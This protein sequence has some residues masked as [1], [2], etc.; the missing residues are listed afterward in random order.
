MLFNSFTFLFG[1]L[2]AAV[3]VYWCLLAFRRTAAIAFLALASLVFYSWWDVRYLP[4]FCGSILF[5]Y[6]MGHL[7]ARARVGQPGKA[8]GLLAF[9]IAADLAVLGYFKYIGLFADAFA[10]LTGISAAIPAVVL[11]L[12]I[13]FFTFTQITYIVDSLKGKVQERGFWNYVL[14]VS[15]FPHQVAGPILHHAEMMSQFRTVRFDPRLTQ[16]LVVGISIFALGLFKK[17]VLADS[18]APYA[19]AVFAAAESAQPIGLLEAWG[20][21]LGYYFQLYFDFSGY[22]DMAIGLSLLFG[23]RLPLNFD[24]PYKATSII[25]FWRRWHITLSRFLRDYLYVPLGGNRKGGA[26]RY[27]NLLITMLLGGLWH[28]AGYTFILWGGLHGAYLMV[29]H[30]W[31]A[32]ATRY[33]LVE[34]IDR[35]R[36]W[37][38]FAWLITTL[39]V[40]VAWVFFRAQSLGGA[41]QLL[42]AM[43]D[44]SRIIL[45]QRLAML[46]EG[47]AYAPVWLA[48]VGDQGTLAMMLLLGF[49]IVLALPNTIS[50][51]RTFSPTVGGDPEPA[52]RLSFSWRPSLGWAACLGLL[53]AFA[54][55]RISDGARFLYFNF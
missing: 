41:G 1:F 11:P 3:I 30:A 15:Y 51:F 36:G 40:V 31:R 25:D 35:S 39:A 50:L 21:A 5:N 37:P 20:G 33:R 38:L 4:L 12:G 2:P 43:F 34:V 32:A 24:S 22:S 27:L 9:A 6:G 19:D 44:G 49:A 53:L 54:V 29:N 10:S 8:R 45:P 47:F 14:F 18:F 55:S 26:R 42:A 13:S 52:G 16:Y 48:R 17:V 46:G 23:V 7:I 28:G